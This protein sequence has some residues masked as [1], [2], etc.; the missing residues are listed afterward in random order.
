MKGPDDVE[1]SRWTSSLGKYFKKVV[2]AN[3]IKGLCKIYEGRKEWLFLFPTFL[4]QLSEGKYH[5][6]GGFIHSKSTL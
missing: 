1:E 3:Q 4:L 5:V 2:P 6:N